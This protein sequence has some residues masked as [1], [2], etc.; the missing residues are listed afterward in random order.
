MPQM[1]P[2]LTLKLVHTWYEESTPWAFNPN[3]RK[4]NVAKKGPNLNI[5]D[6][7]R[8][9]FSEES[10]L[11]MKTL[12]VAS[13][14]PTKFMHDEGGPLLGSPSLNEIPIFVFD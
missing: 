13:L 6:K 3:S 1:I 2:F 8:K 12:I 4:C 10:L 5:F 11:L 14:N 7:L 9:F